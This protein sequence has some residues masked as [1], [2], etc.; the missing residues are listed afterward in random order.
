[1]PARYSLKMSD[2]RLTNVCI[3]EFGE[4][5]TGGAVPV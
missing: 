1:M 3:A 5:P 4:N 2:N